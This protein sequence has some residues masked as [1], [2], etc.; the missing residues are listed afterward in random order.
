MEELQQPLLAGLAAALPAVGNGLAAVVSYG[1]AHL[2]MQQLAAA[3]DT[4]RSKAAAAAAA[5]AE[6]ADG[7]VSALTAGAAAAQAVGA[8]LSDYRRLCSMASSSMGAA[9]SWLARHQETLATLQQQL[10]GAAAA[11]GAVGSSQVQGL[12]APPLEWDA[13]AC[14]RSLLLLSPNAGNA[15]SGASVVALDDGILARSLGAVLSSGPG[16]SSSSS[17]AQLLPADVLQCCQQ[18]DGQGRLLLQQ[19]SRLMALGRWAVAAYAAVLQQLLPGAEE[20]A[21][22]VGCIF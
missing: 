8:H 12:M 11:A 9:G 19:Q 14:D 21:V 10:L 5:A 3:A 16:T 18:A 15:S 13:A 7:E 17:V 22:P 4:A 1:E 2:Y 6:A 20:R